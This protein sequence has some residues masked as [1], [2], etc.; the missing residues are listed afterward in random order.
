MSLSNDPLSHHYNSLR[1]K[2]EKNMLAELMA[3]VSEKDKK[4][5]ELDE[6]F[7]ELKKTIPAL[8]QLVMVML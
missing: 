8:L 2:K 4:I 1:L 6:L 5:E 7:V 3:V